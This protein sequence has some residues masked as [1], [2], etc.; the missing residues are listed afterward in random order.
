MIITLFVIHL[1]LRMSIS[2]VIYS[3]FLCWYR[4]SNNL[5]LPRF[6]KCKNNNGG[7]V[8]LCLITRF[9]AYLI[10]LC[11]NKVCITRAKDKRKRSLKLRNK[12]KHVSPRIISMFR[13][14]LDLDLGAVVTHTSRLGYWLGRKHMSRWQFNSLQT[15][16]RSRSDL[17]FLG[18]SRSRSILMGSVL[19]RFTEANSRTRS[20]CSGLF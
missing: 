5:A 17:R 13:E 15:C 14:H 16:A 12:Q 19:I 2:S 6:K 9:T 1:R 10:H 7:F 4:V 18:I 11:G 3:T 20:I 8:L